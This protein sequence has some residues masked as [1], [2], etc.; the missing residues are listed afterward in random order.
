MTTCGDCG[1][2]EGAIH[3]LGCDVERCP[4]CQGQLI[5][6]DCVYELLG[7]DVS[8]GTWAYEHG[9]TDEQEKEWEALLNKK[10]RIPF[11]LYP[12]HCVRC[13]ELWPKM[14]MVPR[15]E[16]EHYVQPDQRREMLC[17]KCYREI[18]DLIDANSGKAPLR[19][20]PRF[21]G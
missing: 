10:G 12:N 14:F 2:P 4:Y 16:W 21:L 15:E 8:P 9:L 13:G 20:P 1:V 6:C 17:Y 3:E 18:Q 11:I 5:S 7:I 19:H